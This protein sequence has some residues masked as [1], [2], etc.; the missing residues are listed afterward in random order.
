MV[1]EA[2]LRIADDPHLSTRSF[3]AARNEVSHVSF[4]NLEAAR[5]EGFG[6]HR[7]GEGLEQVDGLV[8]PV[9]G[10]IAWDART[11]PEKNFLPPVEREMVD[12]LADE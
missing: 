9:D 6:S 8:E 5:G 12:I 1:K 10:E 2:A 11:V 3:P 4:V 7:E